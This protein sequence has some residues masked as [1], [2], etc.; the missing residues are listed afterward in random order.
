MRHHAYLYL[1]DDSPGNCSEYSKIYAKEEISWTKSK[2]EDD[3][4]MNMDE[5]KQKC[6]SIKDKD[7]KS[8][9][10]V[11]YRVSRRRNK[12]WL[13]VCSIRLSIGNTKQEKTRN[14]VAEECWKLK[15]MFD[16]LV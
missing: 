13:N 1:V 7:I 4:G 16:Q 15:N 10:Y 5:C 2:S 8:C 11:S 12:F 3:N 14:S 6:L 9:E